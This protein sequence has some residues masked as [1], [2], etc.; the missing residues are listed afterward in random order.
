MRVTSWYRRSLYSVADH[1]HLHIAPAESDPEVR[2]R[3]F[4]FGKGES[5][6]NERRIEVG[7]EW[8]TRWGA[9]VQIAGTMV[10]MPVYH[11]G[12]LALVVAVAVSPYDLH[13]VMMDTLPACQV[14][15]RCYLI[16][17]SGDLVAVSPEANVSLPVLESPHAVMLC[18]LILCLMVVICGAGNSH[19]PPAY[20][21][22]RVRCVRWKAV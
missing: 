5:N 14:S 3:P 4:R 6:R 20:V 21:R 10:S 1:Q 12:S 16:D 18:V 11:N 13:R 22:G 2:T 8:I 15:D 7:A 19:D 17:S 9:G